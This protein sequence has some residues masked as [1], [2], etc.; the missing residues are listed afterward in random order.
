ME[1]GRAALKRICM[2][3]KGHFSQQ[4]QAASNNLK[5]HNKNSFE[6]LHSTINS[7]GQDSQLSHTNALQEESMSPIRLPVMKGVSDSNNVKPNDVQT[8][9]KK[10]A[11]TYHDTLYRNW[12][13][14][15][16]NIYPWND[17]QRF[18]FAKV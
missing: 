16:T 8:C 15:G 18:P 9:T 13:I 2:N 5:Q 17:M 4:N 11:L 1:K 6:I 12:G 10:K 3:A 7:S 14:C